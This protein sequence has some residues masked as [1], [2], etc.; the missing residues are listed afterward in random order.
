ML[1]VIEVGGVKVVTVV[2]V[3]RLVFVVECIVAK[4]GGG[5]CTQC[6]CS[7]CYQSV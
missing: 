4:L 3:V 2:T 5:E 7:H 6:Q 1:V